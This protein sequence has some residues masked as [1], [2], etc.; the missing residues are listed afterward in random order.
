MKI[1]I[2]SVVALISTSQ[3][4]KADPVDCEGMARIASI[5]MEKRQNGAAISDIIK[6]VQG[7][8]LAE[9]MV[10]EAYEV[11][12]FKAETWKDSE[13]AEFRDRWYLD[14]YKATALE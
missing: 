14:C 1:L 13:V 8:S 12:R 2:L 5:V 7:N 3:A 10:V 4:A 9:R 11:R 6:I